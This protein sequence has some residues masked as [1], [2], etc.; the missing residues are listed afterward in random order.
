MPFSEPSASESAPSLW[1]RLQ[2]IDLMELIRFGSVGLTSTGIYFALL[3]C[4]KQLLPLPVSVQAAVAY[5]IGMAG[6]YLLHRS[7][8]FRSQRQHTHAGPRY[9][10]VQGTGL[11]VNSAV[12]WFGVD[13]G[14]L[15]FL[16]VQLAALG[17][18]A[19]CSYLG[20]KLW[21]FS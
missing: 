3:W 14:G 4:V 8:T 1:Q 11:L 21:T 15:P 5:V 18:T 9:L 2:Q 13:V 19:G 16:P 12:L 7:F 20:Q 10:A 6:D 17:L